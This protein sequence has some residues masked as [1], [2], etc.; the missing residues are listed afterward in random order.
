M[1]RSARVFLVVVSILNGVAGLICGVLF[2]AKPD[3]SLLQAGALI[4]VIGA[5]PLANIF[6]RD[7]VWIGIAMLLVLG[8]PNTVATVMLL[9]RNER[10]YLLTLVAGVLLIAWTG[11][12]L[13]FMYNVAALAYFMVGVLSVFFSVY[14]SEHATDMSDSG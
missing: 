5:L 7:F 11:F 6:F 8:V 12:E 10:R 14:L 1:R 9:K 13:V 3:G 2:I 4:P